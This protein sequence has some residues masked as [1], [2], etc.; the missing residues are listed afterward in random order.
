MRLNPKFPGLLS[1]KEL[2]STIG[3][4]LQT[5][6][7]LC[8]F[9]LALF[10]SPVIYIFI[11]ADRS[12]TSFNFFFFSS[13]RAAGE[14]AVM[15]RTVQRVTL[16]GEEYAEG[17]LWFGSVGI[18]FASA[19]IHSLI[20]TCTHTHTPFPLLSLRLLTVDLSFAP[21]LPNSDAFIFYLVVFS[22]LLWQTHRALRWCGVKQ[23]HGLEK[24]P[25]SSRCGCSKELKTRKQNVLASFLPLFV[26]FYNKNNPMFFCTV[27]F[28]QFASI[29][30]PKSQLRRYF[31]AL[32]M[33]V[34]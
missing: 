10:F 14:G 30:Q 12:L 17:A 3:T 34:K 18:N 33:L 7:D 26:I 1:Q 13:R 23:V 28:N 32:S 8:C 29:F 19:A 9:S 20:V 11:R 27:A 31:H 25:L 15:F 21:S 5:P 16:A 24:W 2:T 6:L 22:E 4:D